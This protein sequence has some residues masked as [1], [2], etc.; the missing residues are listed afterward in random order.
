MASRLPSGLQDTDAGP[1]EDTSSRDT[2]L[3]STLHTDVYASCCGGG[4][5]RVHSHASARSSGAQVGIDPS[6]SDTRC[7]SPVG[8]MTVQIGE[9]PPH[10]SD[11]NAMRGPASDQTG[12]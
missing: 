10:P 6:F 2:P 7:A 11:Q 9:M 4:P 5:R 8:T 1:P 12:A 3:P